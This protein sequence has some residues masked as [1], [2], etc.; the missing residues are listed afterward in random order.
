[1]E[2]KGSQLI[3]S[4]FDTDNFFM[5]ICEKILDLVTVNLL[6]LVSC[7][8]ILTLGI[9]KMSLYQT[10]FEIK[11]SR[12]VRVVST[13]M[14]AFRANA[15]L[16]LKLGL[17]E[18]AIVGISLFDLLL[19]WGQE[20]L[21]FQVLKAVCLGFI[22][23]TELIA[24]CLYP[25]AGHFD[26]SLKDSLQ[27]SLIV[28]SLNFPWFFFMM[29]VMIGMIIVVYSSGFVLLLGWTIFVILG[30]AGLGFLQIGIL[31]KIFGKYENEKFIKE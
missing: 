8:P 16:G 6:F 23:F 2:K 25:L 1:M 14:K 15:K 3:K 4:I 27:T 10:L 12:R 13:Y 20:A 21:P 17:L 28:V 30:F 18:L 19:F 26:M 7:L 11:K 9:A 24:L 29:A 22:I 31:E 5:Q